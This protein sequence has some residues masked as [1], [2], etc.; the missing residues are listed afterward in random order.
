MKSLII[1]LTSLAF[2]YYHTD[3]SSESSFYSVV[4]PVGVF[5]CL[6]SLVVWITLKNAVA[7]RGNSL[8]DSGAG[9]ISPSNNCD[10]DGGCSD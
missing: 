1:I 5:I 9:F 8:S 2:S 7:A 3:I 4:C 6:L 10:D